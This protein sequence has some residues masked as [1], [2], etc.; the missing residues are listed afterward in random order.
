MGHG[1]GNG[2]GH[3]EG[4]DVPGGLW[5]PTF[6]CRDPL[7]GSYNTSPSMRYNTEPDMGH[8][9]TS[10]GTFCILN[11]EQKPTIKNI[12]RSA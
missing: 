10:G 1:W 12:K 6:I 4:R 3:T 7:C 11:E 2:Y 8:Q 5:E 9:I